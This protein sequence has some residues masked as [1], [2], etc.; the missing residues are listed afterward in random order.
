VIPDNIVVGLML[1]VIVTVFVAVEVTATLPKAKV[2][3]EN[4][5]GATA[6][7]VSVTI[8]GEFR[9]ASVIVITPEILPVVEGVNVAVMVQ[10]APAPRVLVHVLLDGALKSPLNAVAML[11]D[12]PPVFFTVI[13]LPAL[14]VPTAWA[15]NVSLAGVTVI[16]TGAVPVPDSV[17]ICGLGVALSITVSVPG[18]LPVA[19]GENVT[20][21]VQCAFDAR[22]VVHGVAPPAAAE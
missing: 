3:A 18:W 12:S 7:P 15:A 10:V 6:V 14:V 8:C 19:V 11:V 21:M 20:E 13:T 5:T 16:T 2:A 22:L 1:F 17:T 9:P 4:V